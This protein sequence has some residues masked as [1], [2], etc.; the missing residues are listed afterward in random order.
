MPFAAVLALLPPRGLSRGHRG[1]REPRG[2]SRAAEA[3]SARRLEAKRGQV[4]T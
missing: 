4:K 2:K 3:A 1:A